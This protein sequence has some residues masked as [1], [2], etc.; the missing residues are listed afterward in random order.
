MGWARVLI[1]ATPLAAL[2]VAA[3]AAWEVREARRPRSD[4]MVIMLPGPL[5]E[6]RPL[7]PVDEAERQVL[8]LLH[9]PLLR[10]SRD[11]RIMPA[12]AEEWRWFRTVTCWFAGEAQA[13]QAAA[14]LQALSGNTWVA[15]QLETAAAEGAS[16]IMRFVRPDDPGAEEALRAIGDLKPLPLTLARLEVP[17]ARHEGMQ[18]FAEAHRNAIRRLWFD[19]R[20]GCEIVTTLP[21]PALQQRL[22][23]WLRARNEPVLPVRILGE[24]S[25]LVEPVL[26]FHLRKGAKWHDGSPVTPQDV[27]ATV[28]WLKRRGGQPAEALRQVQDVTAGNDN[29]VRVAY[30]R[31]SGGALAAWVGLPMLPE[32]WLATDP[33]ALPP[34][35]AGP[36][37]IASREPG[38]LSLQRSGR[39]RVTFI[40]NAEGLPLRAALATGSLQAAWPTPKSAAALAGEQAWR[41]AAA[42]P[43]SRLLV[44]WNTRSPVLQDPRVRA[45]LALATDRRALAAQ[46]PG[47]VGQPVEGWFR[48]GLWYTPVRTEQSADLPAAERLLAEAGWLRDVAGSVRN[49]RQ[50]LALELLTTAGNPWRRQLTEALARQWQ[51]LGASVTVTEAPHQELFSLR[52]E[53]GRFDAVILGVDYELNWDITDFWRSDGGLN[54]S[55]LA[56]ARLDLLIDAL[57]AEYEPPR[58]PERAKAAE[59]RLLE[60]NVFLPLFS[61]LQEVALHRQVFPQ[62]ADLSVGARLRDL[63]LPAA[64]ARAD[65]TN[66]RMRLPDD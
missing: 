22:A 24:L 55:G 54:F 33:N 40:P 10:L 11:G 12:L 4:E 31:H 35:G 66:L 48:P 16:V 46:L 8:D 21:A 6:L 18:Q 27:R 36:F 50:T 52:L 57:A 32:K 51:Q 25:G 15:G 2:S 39:G 59:D 20:G 28:Q 26:E 13:A 64:P 44:L 56:D 60:L 43:R 34:P 3:L 45:A 42:P 61:D 62:S 14:R 30:R 41:F 38:S 1:F 47:G 29:R 7:Q 23:E 65:S 9:E 17:E 37:Q 5:P 53:P 63:L 19:D 58:V 49:A